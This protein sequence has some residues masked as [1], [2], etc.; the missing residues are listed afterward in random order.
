MQSFLWFLS[1]NNSILWLSPFNVEQRES[2]RMLD[3]PGILEY[4]PGTPVYWRDLNSGIPD[5]RPG[6]PILIQGILNFH[7]G[8][9][10]IHLVTF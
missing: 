10:K 3:K 6:I 5:S 4:I 2:A 7:L 1:I 9:Y 8:I